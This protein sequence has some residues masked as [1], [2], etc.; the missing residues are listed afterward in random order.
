MREFRQYGGENRFIS[1]GPFKVRL[2]GVHYKFEWADYIQGLIMCA[3][4]L[5]IIPVLQETLGMP[6]E[7]AIA[8]VILNGFLYTW[9]TLLGDPVVPGW[10]TPA[11]PLLTAYCLTFP[12]GVPRMHALIAFELGLGIFAIFLG[13]TGL[14]GRLIS[15]VPQAIKSGVIMGAGFS[16]IF[17][18]FK[19]GGKFEAFPITTTICLAVAFY[20]LFSTHF[21][22]L[23]TQG[24]I[25]KS[26]ANLGILPC[27]VVAII[28]APLLGE[29]AWPQIEWSIT[30]PAFGVLWTEW[31]PWGALGWPSAKEFI[32]A[33]PTILATYIVLFGDVVQ[34]QAL[35]KD[36]EIARDDEHV[37]YN[38]NRAH[39]IFGIRN[40]IMGVFGPDIS[41]CGPLWAAMQVVVCERYKKGRDSMDSLLGG[42]ASFRWGTF[43]GYWLMPIVTITKPI[44]P[45]ALSLTM[46][47]QGFVSVR[48]GAMEARSF[49][50][51]GIA[52]VIGGALLAQGAA[53]AFAVG[54][55]ACLLTYGGN[56]F[57]GDPDAGRLWAEEIESQLSAEEKRLKEELATTEA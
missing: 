20:L 15:L 41:M 44:L 50:D 11:I 23:S 26:V 17:M 19:D 33:I 36:A 38:P 24:G 53:Y 2:P 27:I 54:I 48:I 12:A 32:M 21:Q 7:V 14:A 13:V 43:T 47:V 35:V 45:V 57:K 6:F 31:V 52:G 9:H 25:W 3:V 51:L 22:K 30:K 4:C 42:A 29:C 28:V 16:A 5:S 56:F 10:I 55:L 18:I 1:A 34:S 46:I 49:K 8:I 40:C 39:L 37:E